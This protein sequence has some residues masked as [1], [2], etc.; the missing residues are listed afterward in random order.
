[1]SSKSTPRKS[2]AER[3]REIARAV[4]R[5]IGEKGLPS[6]TM[7]AI[8]E[9]VGVTS[10][11]LFR[12]FSSREEILEETV[13]YALARVELTFPDPAL[14]PQERLLQLASNRIRLLS[15]EPG[16]AWLLRF[17]QAYLAL[18]EPAVQILHDLVARSRGF[19]LEALREGARRG[20]FR[21]DI[22]PEV[23]LVPVIG[24]V[25]SLIRTPGI[26]QLAVP[27]PAPDPDV[28]LS[29]LMRLLAPR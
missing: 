9:E 22:E 20:S 3:R 4:L 7:A 5:I 1:M 15:A 6:L 28:V 18:P 27:E 11:A 17:D 23:L 21:D 16:I 19:L 29:A 14:P 24:T 8:A 2:S 25:L 10:G 26:R 13:R 12:H